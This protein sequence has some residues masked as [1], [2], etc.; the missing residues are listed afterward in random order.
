MSRV[1]SY[2]DNHAHHHP[3]GKDPVFYQ[4]IL[5]IIQSIKSRDSLRILDAG[6]GN[7][8][9]I[10]SMMMTGISGTFVGT[11]V[12]YNMIKMAKNNLEQSKE[13]QLFVADG[14]GLPLRSEIKFDIIHIDSVLHHLIKSTRSQSLSLVRLMLRLLIERLSEDG[15]LVIEEM[16]YVSYLIP[17]ITSS[18]IFYGL[19]LINILNLDLSRLRKEFQP[20]LEV[21]F[22]SDKEIEKLLEPYGFVRTIQKKPSWKRIPKFY[23]VFL[24]KESGHISYV[25]KVDR[26]SSK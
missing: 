19:K 22:L 2:F 8:S 5:E 11:D 3:Y 10:K 6:C 21:N 20:G 9:F 17:H 14:F 7:G 25:F 13:V 15:I 16:Y 23:K 12:S 1:K 24:L 4:S 18:I 26:T